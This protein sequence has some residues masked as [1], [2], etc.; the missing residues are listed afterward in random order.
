M[1]YFDL[2]L[3]TDALDLVVPYISQISI[4]RLE[5]EGKKIRGHTPVH[6]LRQVQENEE[7]LADGVICKLLRVRMEDSQS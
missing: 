7:T 4:D 6:H 2:V 3:L 5:D 1:R